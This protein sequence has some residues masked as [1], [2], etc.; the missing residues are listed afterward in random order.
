MLCI[1]HKWFISRSMDSAEPLPPLVVRHIGRCPTCKSFHDHCLALATR[2]PDQALLQ[3][4]EVSGELHTRI[5]R[6]LQTQAGGS[7]RAARSGTNIPRHRP[8]LAPAIATAR[9][10][11][12]VVAVYFYSGW[13]SSRQKSRSPSPWTGI[14]NGEPTV[15]L[16]SPGDLAAESGSLIEEVVQWPLEEEMRLLR[17]DGRAAADF[18]LACVPPVDIDMLTENNSP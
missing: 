17:Q 7:T 15:W 8:I 1:L 9:V 18:L 4:R 12:A 11:L 5:M 6:G 10:L 16:V 2:L 3:T 13:D 14:S